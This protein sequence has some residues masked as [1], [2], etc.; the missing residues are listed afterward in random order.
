MA[1]DDW[2]R[3]EASLE[4]TEGGMDSVADSKHRTNVD[5]DGRD[6]QDDDDDDQ[7]DDATTI[8]NDD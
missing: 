5:H 1:Q 2:A 6:D 4:E 8:E 3:R 7:N